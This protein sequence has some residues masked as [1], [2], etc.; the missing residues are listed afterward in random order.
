MRTLTALRA[1]DQHTLTE[2]D[3]AELY[4]AHRVRLVRMAVLLVDDVETAEDMVQDAFAGLVK[5]GR[6]RDPQAALGYL[7]MAVV[8]NSRSALRRR[9]TVRAH[10]PRVEVAP[11][12]PEAT[13]V[14]REEHREVIEALHQLP[15]RQREVL[16]L[17]YWSDLSEADIAETLGISRGGVKSS[18]SR[19]LDALE[20][21]LQKEVGR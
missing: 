5:H 20:K 6:L 9:R 4:A 7:R 3:I 21:L 15:P 18:A 10:V 12:G 11:S 1:V 13:A 17:R 2:R 16:V 14:L 19:G 8:N